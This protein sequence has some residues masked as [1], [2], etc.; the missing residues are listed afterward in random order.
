MPRLYRWYKGMKYLSV[1]F[2]T[3]FKHISPSIPLLFLAFI[4]FRIIIFTS[5]PSS[6][7]I[8]LA[9]LSSSPYFI[10]TLLSSHPNSRIR[11]AMILPSSATVSTSS[12]ELQ[13]VCTICCAAMSSAPTESRCSSSMRLMRCCLAVSRTKSMTSSKPFPPAPRY[14]SFPLFACLSVRRCALPHTCE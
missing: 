5:L 14:F 1:L 4:C 11:W 7:I 3:S 10:F 9:L 6:L 8:I 2:P 12:S 13:D